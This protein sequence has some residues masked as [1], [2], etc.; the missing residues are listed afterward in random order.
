MNNEQLQAH[1]PIK[2]ESILWQYWQHFSSIHSKS[3]LTLTN[4]TRCISAV[5]SREPECWCVDEAVTAGRLRATAEDPS[6]PPP[7]PARPHPWAGDAQLSP[8]SVPP[9]CI[10]IPT[11]FS[12]QYSVSRFWDIFYHRNIYATPS[13]DILPVWISAFKPL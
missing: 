9:Q 13:R 3:F 12:S 6:S 11:P 4:K 10:W 5:T 8:D 1:E 2:K 7:P